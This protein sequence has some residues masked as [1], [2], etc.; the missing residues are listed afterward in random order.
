MRK[1][2]LCNKAGRGRY[3]TKRSV[4]NVIRYVIREREDEDRKDDLL[5][6]GAC[7]AAEWGGVREVVGAF[8]MVQ[9]TYSRKGSF[10]R[11]IDHEVYVFSD[12]EQEGLGMDVAAFD[13]VAR[14][15]AQDIYRE[16]YQVVYGVHKK[17]GED[18]IHVHL[19]ANTVS[20]RDGRKRREDKART[21]R[22]QKEYQRIVQGAIRER[23]EVGG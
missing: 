17:D 4:G 12:E 14:R 7:G 19:A 16:G 23:R 2:I 1:G 3:R 13:R 18:G 9:R 11:Y 22:R 5:C 6:W 15:M 21:E 10:G 20:Y 8:D